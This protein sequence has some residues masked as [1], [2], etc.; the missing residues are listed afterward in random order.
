MFTITLPTKVR[1]VKAM[2]FPVVMYGCESQTIKKAGRWRIDSFELWCWRRLL[3]V[4]WTARRSNQ[5]ILKEISPGCSL[6]RLMLKLKLQYFGHLTRRVD[7]LEKTLMPGGIRG[8]RRRGW[9][10]MRW[11]DGIT[12][13]R[14]M[15]LSKLWELVMDRKVWHT[16]VQGGHKELDTTEWLNWTGG[17]SGKES[18]CQYRRHGRHRFD[19]WVGKIPWRRKWQPILVFL[20]GKPQGQRSLAGYSLWSHKESDMT[21]HACTH[22]IS[23]NVQVLIYCI[24]IILQI[25]MFPDFN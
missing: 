10:R 4:P 24:L 18:A 9:P 11:L 3:R 7:L 22:C 17:T 21:E 15:S 25:E 1:L 8:R 14:H 13:S 23:C 6:E 16:A 2:V 5:S 19:P 20:L 12:N